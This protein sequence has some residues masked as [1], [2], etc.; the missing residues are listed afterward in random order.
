MQYM[1]LWLAE[2]LAAPGQAAGNQTTPTHT[3]NTKRGSAEPGSLPFMGATSGLACGMA[4]SSHVHCTGKANI[5][6]VAN[7]RSR[8]AAGVC[9]AANSDARTQPHPDNPTVSAGFDLSCQQGLS[10]LAITQ[11]GSA[12]AL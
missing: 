6:S 3:G 11:I 8:P 4:H 9:Q 10:A 2:A 1:D 5:A 7:F 12:V